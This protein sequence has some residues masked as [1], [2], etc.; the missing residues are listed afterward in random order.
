[1]KLFIT[2][3]FLSLFTSLAFAQESCKIV[4][5]EKYEWKVLSNQ[6]NDKTHVIEL[7]PGDQT[8]ENWTLL[9]QMTSVKETAAVPMDKAYEI[10]EMLSKK[11]SSQAKVK[12]LERDEESQF[13]WILIAVENPYFENNPNPESQIHFIKQGKR[14]L[15]MSMIAIKEEKLSKKFIKE[16]TEIFKASEIVEL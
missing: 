7:I 13:P 10:I 12:E 9:G 5:P 6:E 2:Y 3:L 1:M 15:F 11:E 4:W 14:T 16:W 8:A